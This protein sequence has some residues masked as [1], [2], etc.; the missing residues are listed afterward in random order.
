MIFYSTAV[1]AAEVMDLDAT[2]GIIIDK[3]GSRFCKNLQPISGLTECQG[4]CKSSTRFDLGEKIFELVR[5]CTNIF[6]E[7]NGVFISTLR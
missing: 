3:K 2:V 5:K 1:C 6:C 4:N 7:T